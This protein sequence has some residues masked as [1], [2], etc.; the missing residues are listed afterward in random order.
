MSKVQRHPKRPICIKLPPYIIDMLDA[1][2]ESRAVTIERAVNAYLRDDDACK[3]CAGT[4]LDLDGYQD[5]C[6]Y[7]DSH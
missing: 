6:P 3:H 5:V 7:C 4:K 1:L 2:T